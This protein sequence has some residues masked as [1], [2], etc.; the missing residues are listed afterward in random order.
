M[1]IAFSLGFTIG[2]PLGAYFTSFD[3]LKL[4]PSLEGLPINR[5]SSPALF[6]FVLILIETVYLT[7]ALPETIHFKRAVTG[8]DSSVA[9]SQHNVVSH[10]RSARLA[11]KA[12]KPMAEAGPSHV[13]AAANQL[14]ASRLQI[15]SLIHFLFLFFF[16][17]MEFTLTFLTHDRFGFSHSEQ[18]RFLAFMGVLSAL[19]Q[20]GY[21]RRV[22]HK[23]VHERTIVA[24]GIAACGIGLF[25]QGLL[26][27]NLGWLY[28]GAAFLAFTSG[29][30]VTGLTALVSYESGAAK[31]VGEHG[32]PEGGDRGQ[33]LGKFRSLGQLGRALGPIFACTN[34]WVLGSK[35]AYGIGAGAMAVLVVL[36]LMMVP[37]PSRNRVLAAGTSR[38]KAKAM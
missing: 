24:Q 17:G 26:A 7:V 16:S 3:L 30:V 5:Y 38:S 37:G 18:G 11:S 21:T 9:D 35:A 22:A 27:W 25:I 14:K 1:G 20:G 4:F 32:E 31:D 13:S 15:L 8:T 23:S 19:V 28:V 36:V 2:P 6:A 34:Y 33:V 10:T 12:E 29:T